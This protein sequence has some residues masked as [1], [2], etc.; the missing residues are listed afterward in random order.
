MVLVLVRVGL[1]VWVAVWV[2]DPGVGKIVLVNVRE[3][4]GV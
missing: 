1:D 4:V 2:G 3:R